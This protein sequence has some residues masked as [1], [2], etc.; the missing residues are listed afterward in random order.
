MRRADWDPGRA[1]RFAAA[2][3]ARAL[4]A[5]APAAASLAARAA[6]RAARQTGQV[7]T[8]VRYLRQAV[9]L[10]GQVEPRPLAVELAGEA[11]IPLSAALLHLGRPERALDE[12]DEAV[13]QLGSLAA[14][15]GGVEGQAG[16]DRAGEDRAGE[17]DG[18]G[19]RAGLARARGQRADL[20]R[21]IGR[22][23]E[24]LAE[25]QVAI[26]LL[27]AS[28]AEVD[29][30]RSLVNRGIAYT[31]LHAFADAEADLLEADRLARA[32]GRQLA[33]GIIAENLGYL[34]IMRGDVPAALAHL[35]RAEQIIGEHR[36]QL[37]PVF[38]DRSELLLSAG[39]CAEAREAALA[40]ITEFERH[41]RRLLVP[42]AR[43]F[44]AQ[45]ALLDNDPPAA[46]VQARLARRAFARQGRAE[47]AACASLVVVRAELATR[48]DRATLDG[49]DD[50]GV[51]LS[52]TV[53]ELERMV[54]TLARAGWPAAALEARLVA[55]R[56]AGLRGRAADRRRH[57]ELARTAARRGATAPAALRARGWYAEA[58]LRRDGGDRRGAAGAARAGLRVLDEHAASLGATDLRVH[59][60]VHRAEL[61][62]L[63]LRMAFD[64]G[65]PAAVFEWAERGRASRLLRRAVL[66]AEDP[67]LAGL[68]AEL[69]A[70][71]A[72]IDRGRPDPVAQVRTATPTADRGRPRL[73]QRQV[74]LERRIR[75]HIR[76]HPVRGSSAP[77]APV[78]LAQLTDTLGG[79]ALVEFVQ[80]DGELH[81]L[82]LVDGRL[83]RRP[84]G[85]ASVPAGLVQR[86]SHAL[87]R[88]A[89]ADGGP[90]GVGAPATGT[91]P[92]VDEAAGRSR[93][94]AR[95]AA[96][97]DAA[98]ALLTDAARRLDEV[99]L[100]QV[101]E[102]ESRPLVVVPTGPL[103]SVPWSVLPSRAG[104]PVTVAPSATLWHTASTAAHVPG[105]A[106]VAAGP[107]L[108]GAREEA[109][110]IAAIHGVEPLLDDAATADAVLAG[111]AKADVA[112]LAAHGTLTTDNPLFSTLRLHGGPLVVY[113]VE[114]LA[115]VP[116][117]VVLASC[118]SGR[119]MV[120]TGDE[121]LG[122]AATFI[123][124]GA[125]ELV[126]SVVPV[127][128]GATAPLM[129]ALHRGLAAGVPAPVALAEAQRELRDRSP[130][131]LAA[132][133]GFV[134]LG[135]ESHAAR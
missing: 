78:S 60:A 105:T 7:D 111:L 88:L 128:D 23:G 119:S 30:Q 13:R 130:A 68:L 104:R 42:G 125:A 109:T 43:L 24:A 101:P 97:R 108:P 75:D 99:L 91:A 65:G 67:E 49:R 118:D 116:R 82:V 56:V 83:R 98:V 63:G 57:L 112:H 107:G 132:A 18:S 120:H 2:V 29:L 106:M 114:R 54:D 69:R 55:A 15:F 22:P 50:A 46:L 95:P 3:L 27:R 12:I 124:R 110:A 100:G 72:E 38:A 127:P 32:L 131:G 10:A 36:G 21:Q 25:F 103:H 92:G 59:S 121:L 62:E 47:W 48:D 74:A 64:G 40:A 45:A 84:L 41:R 61:S 5:D 96:S 17:R 113:D 53:R 58:L 79:R 1:V 94:G 39:V 20:L 81:A 129:I 115:T 14:L 6:G 19:R 35:E 135:G 66:P 33:V 51:R 26:P 4:R 31:E 87:R 93:P 9:E 123:A 16:D 70:T 28:G 8:A 117:T 126:A 77:A 71:I 122:L 37:G 73:T 102:I 76:L 85:P 11:R 52:M 133:A 44:L 134:T 89:R 34:E 86:L 90:W 80:L